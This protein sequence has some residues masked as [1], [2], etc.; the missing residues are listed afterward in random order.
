M[1]LWKIPVLGLLL[2]NQKSIGGLRHGASQQWECKLMLL[3][4]LQQ[5][6]KLAASPSDGLHLL[7]WAPQRG[8]TIEFLISS[9]PAQIKTNAK[10]AQ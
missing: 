7:L 3:Y 2:H 10:P 6:P 1:Y 9:P 8:L 4:L 5:V